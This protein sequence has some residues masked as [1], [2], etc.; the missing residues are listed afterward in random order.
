MIGESHSIN[1]IKELISIVAISENTNVLITGESGTGKEIVAR[2]IHQ[3]S[4][5]HNN[6][7]CGIN[8]SAVPGTLF[9]SQF[10][11]HEKNAFTGANK[12]HIG[13]FEIADGGTLFL[14]EI[15]TMSLDQQVKLLRV[16]EERKIIRLGSHRE[17]PIDVH[18]IS[19]SNID[20][21]EL[22]ET[23]VFRK[24]LYHRL[25]T[26]VIR[27]PP[28]RERKD[29]I[30]LL[31]EHFVNLFSLQL[32]KKIKKIEKS[33]EEAL[34]KYHF[35]GNVR[36]LK[37]IIERAMIVT[38]SSTLKLSHFSVPKSANKDNHKDFLPMS[39]IEK[40]HITEA[41]KISKYNQSHAADLLKIERRAVARK[42]KK[43]GIER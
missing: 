40:L 36:E 3:N 16:L 12:T 33:V 14:D 8:S 18:I 13:W 1:K 17:I 21:V 38:D 39:E 9:E 6:S 37:N 29:D 15:G 4:V 26:F 31:L 10:F 25:A 19:A 7:F 28:L 30:P 34:M 43:Y 2:Q 42:M 20:L 22:V 23:N 32:K 41:L 11:G 27:I 24:D 35:P 5:R